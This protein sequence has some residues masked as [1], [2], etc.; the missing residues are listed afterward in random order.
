MS[1]QVWGLIMEN[2]SMFASHD[3]ETPP[4]EVFSKKEEALSHRIATSMLHDLK[5]RLEVK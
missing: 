3:K 2:Y 4:K 5:L 1:Y